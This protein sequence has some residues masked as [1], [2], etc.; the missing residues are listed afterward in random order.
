MTQPILYAADCS[1]SPEL[2]Q[3][4]QGALQGHKPL[5]AG[6]YQLA[7]AVGLTPQLDQLLAPLTQSAIAAG[8]RVTVPD[9]AALKLVSGMGAVRP[10]VAPAAPQGTLPVAAL[11]GAGLVLYFALNW[12]GQHPVMTLVAAAVALRCYQGLGAEAVAAPDAAD[13][14]MHLRLT[15]EQG[16]TVQHASVWG[17]VCSATLLG[18][19][20]RPDQSVVLEGEARVLGVPVS[21]PWLC[22]QASALKLGPLCR[23]PRLSAQ[24]MVSPA[25]TIM[26]MGPSWQAELLPNSQVTLARMTLP[27]A[28]AMQL[29]GAVKI[30]FDGAAVAS[31]GP[32]LIEVKPSITVGRASGRAPQMGVILNGLVKGADAQALLLDLGMVDPTFLEGR[33]QLDGARICYTQEGNLDD[34]LR[35]LAP[36]APSAG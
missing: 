29:K 24:L 10:A 26:A 20:W 30:R 25:N 18:L 6:T 15:I 22:D 2:L 28:E 34:F 13:A 33:L 12:A 32:L 14:R 3:S 19:T 36:Q 8:L 21:L 9:A 27:G 11:V 4:G 23:L 31:Q 17:S 16:I 35:L 1:Q 7:D 5:P